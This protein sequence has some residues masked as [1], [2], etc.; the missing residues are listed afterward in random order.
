VFVVRERAPHDLP[1]CVA[2]LRDVHL[3]DGYPTWWP[4]DPSGWLSPRG[5]SAAWVA[6]SS[7]VVVGHVSVVRGVVD[8][9]VT[10][11]TGAR[12]DQLA[13]VSRLFVA[14]EARGQ[15]LGAA[16]LDA[17]L[18]F[19]AASSLQLMLD[20]V[21]DGGAAVALYERLGWRLVD[22][23][24]ADWTTPDSRRH[25]VRIYVAPA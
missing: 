25:T 13:S 6:E 24:P 21:E 8:P 2:A 9:A 14:P 22:R 4:A 16:L 18:S 23:R 20:V 3:A 10:T 11:A 1:A 15:G 5:C 19:A 12:P 7:G 17:S